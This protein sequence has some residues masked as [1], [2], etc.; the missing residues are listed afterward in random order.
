MLDVRNVAANECDRYHYGNG[1]KCESKLFHPRPHRREKQ[2][3]G[4][5]G[6][7]T[8]SLDWA[9]VSGGVT[10]RVTPVTKLGRFG[11]LHLFTQTKTD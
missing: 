10:K 1:K 3:C 2:D 4:Q 7:P 6:L 5:N 8:V 11:R 9:R